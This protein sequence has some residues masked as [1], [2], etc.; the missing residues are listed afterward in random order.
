V[1][2]YEYRCREC[3]KRFEELVSLASAD[4]VWPCP[5]C[6]CTNT[7]RL[8]SSFALRVEGGS[9][10][11]SGKNCSTCSRSSCSTC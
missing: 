8:L 3:L 9:G 1:P 7:E 4:D 11:G 6:A 5:R 2:I 10:S